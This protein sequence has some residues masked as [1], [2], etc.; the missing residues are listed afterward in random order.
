MSVVLDTW[1]H[2]CT[3]SQYNKCNPSCEYHYYAFGKYLNLS[4]SAIFRAEAE[5]WTR[6]NSSTSWYATI[7]LHRPCS[8]LCYKEDLNVIFNN[9]INTYKL[10]IVKGIFRFPF[11]GCRWTRCR[12]LWK[13]CR[14]QRWW[15]LTMEQV[16]FFALSFLS[17]LVM[18]L[19][20]SQRSHGVQ[21]AVVC[22]SRLPRVGCRGVFWASW[23]GLW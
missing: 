12:L 8:I 5:I 18:R 22:V 11:T 4:K 3:Y 17:P 7:T 15:F 9:L 23:A 19:V 13:P 14:L 21:V 20:R 6:T 10:T 16:S 1:H 2:S